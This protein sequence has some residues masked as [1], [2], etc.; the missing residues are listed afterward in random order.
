MA[1]G[2]TSSICSALLEVIE[3]GGTSPPWDGSARRL[4]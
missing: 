2:G 1:A 4:G 3:V